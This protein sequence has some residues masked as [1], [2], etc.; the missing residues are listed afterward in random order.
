[1]PESQFDPIFIFFYSFNIVEIMTVLLRQI[2]ISVKYIYKFY[3]NY[4]YYLYNIYFLVILEIFWEIFWFF[5]V[6]ILA[7]QEKTNQNT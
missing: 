7:I 1:M 6:C 4:N 2:T 5:I 3:I